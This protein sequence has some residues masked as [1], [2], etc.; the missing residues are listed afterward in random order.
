[1]TCK[2]I[3]FFIT[4]GL[5]SRGVVSNDNALKISR[6]TGSTKKQIFEL[7]KTNFCEKFFEHNKRERIDITELVK[8]IISA[9]ENEQL[10]A[11][12]PGRYHVGFEN[13]VHNPVE[14]KCVESYVT[15]L[16]NLAKKLDIDKEALPN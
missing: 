12:R 9:Y 16:K 15:K 8:S 3:T 13:F 6:I 4:D 10:F 5:R 2:Y 7:Y 11:N 14:I 1:M